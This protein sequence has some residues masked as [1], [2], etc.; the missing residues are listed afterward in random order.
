AEVDVDL[1]FHDR[2]RVRS[3]GGGSGCDCEEEKG[4]NGEDCSPSARAHAGLSARGMKN[5][6][7]LAR[8]I[9]MPEA[10]KPSSPS[11]VNTATPMISAIQPS[12]RIFPA[13]P[14]IAPAAPS[15]MI[16]RPEAN[17]RKTALSSAFSAWTAEGGTCLSAASE[18]ARRTAAA[19]RN[20]AAATRT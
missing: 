18:I 2:E 17:A 11:G 7:K 9:Q 3:V 10:K 13:M 20:P 8:M 15:S 5:K 19:T 1:P 4:C 16:P 6:A 14:I 12:P